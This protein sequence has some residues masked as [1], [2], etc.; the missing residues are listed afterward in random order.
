MVLAI[1]FN[2]SNFTLIESNGK[3]VLFLEHIKEILNL[4]NVIIVNERT[5]D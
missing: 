1:I 2:N 5:E 4:K 3:K